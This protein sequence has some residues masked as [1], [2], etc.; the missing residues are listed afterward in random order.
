MGEMVPWE[1]VSMALGTY[2]CHRA[3]SSL[4]EEYTKILCKVAEKHEVLLIVAA[5]A[6]PEELAEEEEGEEVECEQEKGEEEGSSTEELAPATKQV[7]V[8]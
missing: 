2:E 8:T 4:E 6:A 5:N 7:P 3:T 1:S